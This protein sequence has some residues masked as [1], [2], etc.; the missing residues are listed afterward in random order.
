MAATASSPWKGPMETLTTTNKKL[1][2]G[3]ILDEL[4]DLS[5]YKALRGVTSGNLQKTLDE[6][7]PIE[8]KHYAFW[9]EFY[10]LRIERLDFGRRMKLSVIAFV[11]IVF[12]EPSVYLILEAIEIYGIRKYLTI[13]KLYQN[14]PLAAAVKTVLE[15]EFGHED[16]VVSG[17]KERKISPERI[18]VIFLG[19]N[20][21]LVEF[22]GAV[23]GFF[24]AFQ[25]AGPV[26]IA[27]FTG[28]AAGALSM[29]VGVFASSGFEEEM[30]R[31]A[32]GKEEFLSG[33][34]GEAQP[35]ARP[36]GSAVI[37]GISY[38]F[39]AMIPILPV[40]F[41]AKNVFISW[42]CGGTM[43]VLVTV[44]LSFISGTRIKQRILTN[45]AM[46]AIAVAGAYAVGIFVK[47]FM[48]V[49]AV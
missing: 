40:F 44:I 8:T 49:E 23:G 16:K 45:L 37:V 20:D 31:S 47:N 1:A 36:L 19:F 18:R 17:L 11:C 46:V 32:L 5:L 30:Q 3:L 39:G 26:L 29:A 22:L 48:G 35:V 24:A 10:G 27:S 34:G 25:D 4:F 14:T 28:A 2:E 13:W 33:G 7:V 9:Q 43:V 42:A 12:G 15:D 41:G 21:G 6:L 38:L